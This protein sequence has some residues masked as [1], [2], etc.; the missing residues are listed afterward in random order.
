MSDVNVHLPSP[1]CGQTA[2]L[3]FVCTE[4]ADRNTSSLLTLNMHL[5]TCVLC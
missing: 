1:Y 5:T 4:T 2:A 3:Q